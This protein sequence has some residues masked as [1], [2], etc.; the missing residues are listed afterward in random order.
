MPLLLFVPALVLA[1][2]MLV[3]RDGNVRKSIPKSIFAALVVLAILTPTPLLIAF[4]KWLFRI[5]S[6]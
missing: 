5:Q 4:F 3:R 2:L 1:V 6:N